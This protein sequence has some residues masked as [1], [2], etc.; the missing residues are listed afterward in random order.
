MQ[1]KLT[2]RLE[3]TVIEAAK[4][5]AEARGTSVS[6][7]VASYLAALTRVEEGPAD[8]SWKANLSPATQRLVGIAKPPE[9]ATG[10]DETDYYQHL[11]EKHSR[12]LR[13]KNN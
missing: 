5:Y 2:L 9:G 11:E 12:H 6:K 7:L 3:E 8:D 13:D 1:T 4:Q 10:F